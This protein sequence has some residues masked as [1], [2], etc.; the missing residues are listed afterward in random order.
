VLN[1]NSLFPNCPVQKIVS[2]GQ[3]GVDRAA[4]AVAVFLEIPHGGWCPAGRRAEDGVIPRRY[5]LQETES[6]RYSDRTLRNVI[7]SDGT[8]VLSRGE[9][10]G[11]TALTIQLATRQKRPLKIVDLEREHR[12]TDVVAWLL[13][14]QIRVLNVAGPRE[15]TA[16]SITAEAEQYLI[17]CLTG[18]GSGD[19]TG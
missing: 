14:H 1:I 15:S 13:S 6:A 18:V 7:D 3:T 10:S 2:G 8:L 9:A 16:P 11:G 4:L 17:N 5:S 12:Y 19:E